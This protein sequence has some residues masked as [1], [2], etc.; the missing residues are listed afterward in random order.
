MTQVASTFGPRSSTAT[1]V[2]ATWVPNGDTPLGYR[3]WTSPFDLQATVDVDLAVF[4][5][6]V[7]WDTAARPSPDPD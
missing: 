5:L 2:T 1:T 3:I 7:R 6:A 4:R